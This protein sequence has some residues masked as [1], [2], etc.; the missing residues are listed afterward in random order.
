MNMSYCRFHNTHYDL[1][2]CINAVNDREELS[3]DE[4]CHL[5]SMI[6]LM[7]DFLS[8]NELIDFENGCLDDGQV[9]TLIKEMS[10]N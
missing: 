10:G 3:T 6:E 4:S 2:D 8:E 1:N 9:N 7:F 5:R